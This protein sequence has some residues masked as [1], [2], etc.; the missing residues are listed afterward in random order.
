MAIRGFMTNNLVADYDMYKEFS[1][2][3]L[4]EIKKDGVGHTPVIFYKPG[5]MYGEHTKGNARNQKMYV[6]ICKCA[7]MTI[8]YTIWYDIAKDYVISKGATSYKEFVDIPMTVVK[9]FKTRVEKAIK[10]TVCDLN[11]R[12]KIY[13]GVK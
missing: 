11:G 3:R 6:A 2:H 7:C 10:D 4:E 12:T 9:K 13:R 1:K 5:L 8:A